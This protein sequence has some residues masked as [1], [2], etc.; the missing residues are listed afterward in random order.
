MNKKLSKYI[1]AL[2]YLD[3]TLIVL[4]A[5]SGRGSNISFA[6][7]IVVPAG[8][9]SASFTLL[10]SL[11]TN[12]KLLSITRNKKRRN[13]K[14]IM[15]A[16][17]KLNRIDTLISQAITDRKICHEEFKTIINEKEKYETM[18]ENIRTMK[19]SYELG[20]N[21]KNTANIE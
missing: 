21:N 8:I 7:V 16:K 11:T 2:D 1:A 4:C 18:K 17:S 15:L 13:K 12:N 6:S 14:I 9:A 3:K 10:F 20:E 5:T 19:S